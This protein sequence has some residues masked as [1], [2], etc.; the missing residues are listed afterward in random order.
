MK[1]YVYMSERKVDMMYPQIPQKLRD[2]LG[3]KIGINLGLI[4]SE[5][6][7]VPREQTLTDK[8]GIIQQYILT[9]EV[10]KTCSIDN[11]LDPKRPYFYVKAIKVMRGMVS[12]LFYAS[13]KLNDV[14][15]TFTGSSAHIV[16][17]N[18]LGKYGGS[19]LTSMA[20]AVSY[21]IKGDDQIEKTSTEKMFAEYYM[22]NPDDQRHD[23]QRALDKAHRQAFGGGEG[24]KHLPSEDF[25]ILG[26]VLYR[27]EKHLLVSPIFV[28]FID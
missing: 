15:F 22:K 12:E 10:D 4:R 20:V 8:I 17:G 25:E 2:N 24:L 19:D 26:R 21:L 6:S 5:W 23:L 13:A 27:T 28:A 18:N 1:Y 11:Y 7:E 16:G 3:G 9:E 14:T